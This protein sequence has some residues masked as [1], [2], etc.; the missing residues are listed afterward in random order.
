MDAMFLHRLFE[1]KAELFGDKTAVVTVSESVSFRELNAKA[2]QLAHLLVQ[3]AAGAPGIVGV[4]L[5]AG[6][7]HVVALLAIFK[8]GGVYL[9]LDNAFAPKR[10]AQILTNTECRTLIFPWTGFDQTLARLARAGVQAELLIAC[11]EEAFEAYRYRDGAWRPVRSSRQAGTDNL[12]LRSKPEDGNYIFHTSG[13]TGEPKAILGNHRGLAHFIRWQ[14]KEFGLDHTHRVSQLLQVTFDGALRDI[15]VPLCTGSALCIPDA[16]VKDNPALL[17]DWLVAQQISII[18]CV[19][20]LF[21][22]LTR[23]LVDVAAPEEAFANLRYIIMAG[24]P[25]FA[26]DVTSWRARAGTHTEI[27]NLYGTS[28]TTLAKTFHRVTQVPDNPGEVL[29]V[30]KPIDD[31]FIVIINGQNEL[32]RIG[33]IGEI[34]IKTPFRTNGYY[35]NEALNRQAFVQNPLVKDGIDILHKTGDI[36]RYLKDRSVEVLGRADNQVKINGIRVELQEIEK[37]LLG[38][39]GIAEAIVVVHKTPDQQ[40]ELVAYYTGPG[41]SP[42][43]VREALTDELSASLMPAYIIQLEELPLTLNGKI[44]KKMLPKPREIILASGCY[45]PP[46]NQ[47]ERRL[48]ALW[49]ELLNYPHVSRDIS[50][51]RIGGH[52][53]KAMQMVGRIF[54][55]FGVQ[56]RIGDVLRYPTIEQIARLIADESGSPQQ[57]IPQ[58]PGQPCYAVSP[59]QKRFWIINQAGQEADTYNMPFAF[60]LEGD[61]NMT[62]L[63]EAVAGLIRRHEVLHTSFDMVEGEVCQFIHDP[64]VL[65]VPLRVLHLSD[66]Q[67]AAGLQAAIAPIASETFALD[68]AP[69]L[70][71]VVVPLAPH[72]HLLVLNLHHIIFDGWSTGIFIHELVQLYNASVRHEKHDLLPLRVQY[73]DYAAWLNKQIEQHLEADKAYWLAQ[74]TRPVAPLDLPY[75]RVETPVGPASRTIRLALDGELTKRFKKLLEQQDATLFMGV[76]AAFDVLLFYYTGSRD[77]VIGAPVSMRDRTDLDGQLGLYLNT[78]AFRTVFEEGHS[79]LDVLR[80][81]KE[82]VQQRFN[83]RFLPYD[84][85]LE[86]LEDYAPAPVLFTVVIDMLGFEPAVREGGLPVIHGL[87]VSQVPT[88]YNS[89][90]FDVTLYCAEEEDLC[91]FF[92]YN[93]RI[94]EAATIQAMA[95]R[96]QML[97]AQLVE[98]P[99]QAVE[100]ISLDS[101]VEFLSISG[102]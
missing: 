95:K 88:H 82:N 37:A 91:F 24:E 84:Q 101:T 31:A 64:E 100:E 22:L 30:G 65:G 6:L 75:D 49:K 66:A 25:L 86:V 19:P 53:L 7:Q 40:S 12:P 17:A 34:Y 94:F 78:L 87:K 77:I 90:K 47:V 39:E 56:L 23:E 102:F 2:N 4:N 45:N 61:L 62:A 59:A 83:H 72:E 93:P 67:K 80:L 21:R 43:Q 16:A 70:K 92:D 15:W 27:V 3:E 54:K 98:H 28:E 96:F 71:V 42:G 58:L 36:G 1:E 63:R 29:H 38:V 97:I 81:V 13:S 85:V 20:S 10:F 11:G 44:D 79:F 26:K 41:L 50:F 14:V 32:C 33:E 55:E 68:K 35:R 69:L 9:P 46:A 18:H 60:S 57:L 5:P 52:S 76:K 73:K 89:N 99:Q 8:A 74:F 51:F 48:E